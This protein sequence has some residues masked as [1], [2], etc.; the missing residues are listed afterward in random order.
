LEKREELDLATGFRGKRLV[1]VLGEFLRERGE[2]VDGLYPS[3]IVER[4]FHTSTDFP[5]ILANVA[6]KTLRKSYETIPS[7]WRPLVRV[8]EVPDFKEVKRVQIGDAPRLVHKPEGAEVR[9]GSFSEAQE[10]FNIRTFARAISITREMVINDDL[11][12]LERLPSM[13]ARSCAE[14]EADL[15]WE[16]LLGESLMSDGKPVFDKAHANV[17]TAS[18]LDLVSYFQ[19]R[20]ALRLQKGLDDKNVSLNLSPSLLFIPPSLELAAL[21]LFASTSPNETDKVNPYAGAHKPIVEARL[22]DAKAWILA[23]D[24]TQIDMVELAYLEGARGPRIET[25]T[26]FENDV[27]RMKVAMDVGAKAIDWRGFQKINIKTAA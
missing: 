4:S 19:A 3:E 27:T 20:Q 2:R 24:P 1:Q 11:S 13:W 5:I 23:A 25:E 15:V 26:K 22:E 16:A 21:K 10:K 12:A 7:N 8:T 18:A 17:M 9:Y 6:R 14:L